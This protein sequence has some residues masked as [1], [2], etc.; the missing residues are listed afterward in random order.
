MLQQTRAQSVIPYYERFLERFPAPRDLAE[1]A[2]SEV[3]T[4]WSGLGY[5]QRARNLRRAAQRIVEAGGFPSEYEAIRELPGV[6]PYTAA[7]V[8]SIAFG[9]GRAVVDGNVLR[10]ISRITVD[11]SDI[12]APATKERFES[13]AEGLLDRRDPG[14]FNQAMM[15][16]GATICLPRDPLC[17]LCPVSSD[18]KARIEGKQAQ[19]PVKL[20][21]I[22]PVRVETTL[23]LVERG[24]KIL[25]WRRDPDSLRLGGFWELPSTEDFPEVTPQ[26]TLGS[27]RH[28]ITNHNYT[29]TVM[30]ARVTRA[31]NRFQ[32][33]ERSELKQLPL[34]TT[35]RKAMAFLPSP[36]C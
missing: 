33:I 10:V 29:C 36:E 26:E 7:A 21:R 35:A 4:H 23:L 31:S 28:S 3:L 14:R 16:L 20:K 32:W 17:L 13:V 24:E 12:G 5:Y 1:A 2:E 27:F 6:G 9:I 34:S 18:C 25:L 19:L 22:E 15:E 8:G 30:R 11:P